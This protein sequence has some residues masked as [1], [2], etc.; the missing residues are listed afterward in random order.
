LNFM[1]NEI[2]ISKWPKYQDGRTC[3]DPYYLL[4]VILCGLFWWNC[5]F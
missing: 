3:G 4:M 1:D 2:V 5:Y